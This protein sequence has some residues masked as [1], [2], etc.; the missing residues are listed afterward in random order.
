MA[1]RESLHA[2]RVV[3]G[4]GCFELGLLSRVILCPLEMDSALPCDRDFFAPGA[5]SAGMDYPFYSV[6]NVRGVV[7]VPSSTRTSTRRTSSVSPPGRVPGVTRLVRHLETFDT[8]KD[9]HITIV[10]GWRVHA[11]LQ[12]LQVSDLN[13]GAHVT[14]TLAHGF[15]SRLRSFSIP[16]RFFNVSDY[17]RFRH[18]SE[19]FPR[20]VLGG[21]RSFP[22]RP[23][24]AKILVEVD[25]DKNGYLSAA[26]INSLDTDSLTR[27]LMNRMR[28]ALQFGTYI[29]TRSVTPD[30]HENFERQWHISD[31]VGF[32]ENP[33]VL[34]W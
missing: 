13:V 9:G 5:S 10:E 26:E 15:C 24:L 32:F 31:V 21:F 14:T 1:G 30:L 29:P 17:Q 18:I 27:G 23:P 20:P 7:A 28:G 2:L 19:I 25:A 3:R 12:L 6:A 11:E 22:E 4:A 33:E 8:D 34:E 16:I